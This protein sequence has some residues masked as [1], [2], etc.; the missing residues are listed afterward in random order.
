MTEI[1]QVEERIVVKNVDAWMRSVSCGSC[2]HPKL[3]NAAE[4][5]MS[6]EFGLM[7]RRT[8]AATWEE[9]SMSGGTER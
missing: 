7:V 1:E 6:S 3:E 4:R 5:C 9:L 2:F 8:S